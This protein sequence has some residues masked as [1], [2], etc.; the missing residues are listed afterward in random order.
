MARDARKRLLCRYPARMVLPMFGPEFSYAPVVSLGECRPPGFA[1]SGDNR[2]RGSL[3][4]SSGQFLFSAV[5]QQAEQPELL[6][7]RSRQADLIEAAHSAVHGLPLAAAGELRWRRGGN[8]VK[9]GRELGLEGARAFVEEFQGGHRPYRC[10]VVDDGPGHLP[11][12][13]R[14]GSAVSS[15]LVVTA[16]RGHSTDR[17]RPDLSGRRDTPPAALVGY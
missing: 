14:A 8:C 2:D 17:S 1:H 13:I 9:H 12:T 3:K 16:L 11:S 6:T 5:L 10:L 15:M 4:P 7:P